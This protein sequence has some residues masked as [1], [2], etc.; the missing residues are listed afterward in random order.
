MPQGR[1]CGAEDLEAGQVNDTPFPHIIRTDLATD[2]EID[3]INEEWPLTGWRDKSGKTSIKSHTLDLPP[4]AEKVVKRLTSPEFRAEL[5]AAFGIPD[6]LPDPEKF[7]AGLHC[8]RRGGFL[9]M[10]VDFNRH[11]SGLWRRV[12]LLLYLNREWRKSWGGA[13]RLEGAGAVVEIPPNAGTAVIFPTTE[14]SWHGHPEPL[15]CPEGRERRSI[16]I[17]YYTRE[18]P[19]DHAEPHTTIYR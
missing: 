8:I 12:N 4:T 15:N 13:L 3:A 18:A 10:H 11:P 19:A 17:Y 6:L 1:G 2:A 9:G 7:G 16:A 14:T 5:S